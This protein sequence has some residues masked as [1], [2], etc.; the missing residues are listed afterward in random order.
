MKNLR[1]VAASILARLLNG[2]G[3]LSSHLAHYKDSKDYGLLQEICFGSCRWFHSLSFFTDQLLEKP[4]KQKDS[5]IQCLLVIGLYQLRELSIPQHA[6]LNETVAATRDLDKPWAKALVNAILRNYLRKQE[7]L[8]REF[9][10]DTASARFSFPAWL[11]EEFSTAWPDQWQALIE[12][13]NQRPPM[14]LRVNHAKLSRDDYLEKL[15]QQGIDA[16]SGGLADS[17]VYLDKPMAVTD[18]PGFSEGEVSVQDEASQLVPSLLQLEPGLRVLDACAAPG[19]KTCHLLESECSLTELVAVDIASERSEMIQENLQR[20]Q[21]NAQIICADILELDSWWDSKPFD[22]VLVDAPCSATGVIRRHPDIK[23]LRSAKE[24][25]RLV[26]LQQEI[27]HSLWSCLEPDGLLLYTTCSLLTTEND[28]QIQR[29]LES[30]DNAKYEGIA[31]DWGV[32]C[33]YGRQLPTGT[34]DGP[35]GFFY[36]LLRKT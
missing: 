25:K 9:L 28:Q 23:L 31:A 26:S 8:E 29:F 15:K 30:T 33:R 16:A 18:I 35:D 17:S 19:G 21:L 32:E 4:L 12:N 7:E 20:L 10:Q 22:R 1:A 2:D 5:D 6:V 14:T 24:V 36:S 27:L 13:S 34:Q 3:S 11:V